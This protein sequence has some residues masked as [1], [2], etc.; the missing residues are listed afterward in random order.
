M[1][2]VPAL[3]FLVFKANTMF[4]YGADTLTTTQDSVNVTDF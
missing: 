2:L 3:S 1:I 4:T